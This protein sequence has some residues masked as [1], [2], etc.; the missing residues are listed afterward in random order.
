MDL[1]PAPDV[2]TPGATGNDGRDMRDDVVHS[3]PTRKSRD[4]G[5]LGGKSQGR[6]ARHIDCA[7]CEGP[8]GNT[9]RRGGRA[10]PAKHSPRD[11]DARVS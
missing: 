9:V 4:R 8:P 10:S 11:R 5:G 7:P 1:P 2:A 3:E 6:F